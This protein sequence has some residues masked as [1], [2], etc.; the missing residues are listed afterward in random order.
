MS[1]S[2]K[3]ELEGGG[4][5]DEGGGRLEEG[6]GRLEDGGGRD[7]LGAG[8]GSVETWSTKSTESM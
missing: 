8:T 2:T 5:L 4:R 6:G 7:E 1:G 3:N